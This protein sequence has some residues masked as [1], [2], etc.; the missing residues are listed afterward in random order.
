MKQSI[1]CP[2]LHIRTLYQDEVS[3]LTNSEIHDIATCY[4]EIFSED[5][6]GEKWSV[7]SAMTEVG[8]GLKTD[9]KRRPQLS[10]LLDEN[11]IVGFAWVVLTD[12][13]SLNLEDMP[14]NL[15]QSKKHQA[16]TTV[17]YWLDLACRDKVIIFKEIGILKT[18]RYRVDAH[19]AS[20]MTLPLFNEAVSKGHHCVICWTSPGSSSFKRSIRFGWHPI[21]IFHQENRVIFKGDIRKSIRYIKGIMNRDKN[22]FTEMK[23][24]EKAYFCR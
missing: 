19:S 20:E 7:E 15:S 4:S 5:F 10:L 12:K 14:I 22:A 23:E 6:W 1:P 13:D 11:S 16:L 2:D 3:K 18:Y 17:Q 24:N 21:C 8:N 9:E